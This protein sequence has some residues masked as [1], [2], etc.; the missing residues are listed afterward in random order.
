MRNPMAKKARAL[1]ESKPVSILDVISDPDIFLPWFK[2][3]ESW[4]AWICFLK[5]MFGHD[6]DQA[7][8]KIYRECTHRSAPPP[9]GYLTAALVIGRRGGKSLILATIAAYLAAFRDWTPHLTGGETG[10]L[11]I[12]AADRRQGKAILGYLKGMLTIPLLAG[13]I[14]RETQETLE[15]GSKSIAISIETASFKT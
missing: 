3:R 5:V 6:L 11:V 10:H 14:T 1:V 9:S 7:E 8:L 13:L 12:L 2:D 4:A 15:I